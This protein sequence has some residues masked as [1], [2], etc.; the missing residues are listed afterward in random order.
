MAEKSAEFLGPCKY[1]DKGPYVQDNS[2][3]GIVLYKQPPVQLTET[4]KLGDYTY[5]VL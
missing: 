3:L 1:L 5:I 4:S 2:P